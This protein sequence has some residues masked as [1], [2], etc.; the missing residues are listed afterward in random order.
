MVQDEWFH[1][2]KKHRV[3]W[4][5]YQLSYWSLETNIDA[6]KAWP[7]RILILTPDELGIST[8]T[9]VQKQKTLIHTLPHIDREIH[10][11]KE[12]D[13]HTDT[14]KRIHTDLTKWMLNYDMPKKPV[15][16]VYKVKFQKSLAGIFEDIRLNSSVRRRYFLT[17]AW[18]NLRSLNNHV[19]Q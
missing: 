4:R 18:C 8:Y 1:S 10:I 3:Y 2:C 9:H 5:V 15:K 12:I 19:D 16:F 7:L 11:D 6:A 17:V 14:H 13:T